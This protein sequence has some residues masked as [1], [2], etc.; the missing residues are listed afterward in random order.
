MK[1]EKMDKDDISKPCIHAGYEIIPT[2]SL[3]HPLNPE[4]LQKKVCKR[5]SF[6]IDFNQS[7]FQK[8]RRHKN[9]INLRQ[10]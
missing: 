6:I 3:L 10:L 4:Y 7:Q 5:T 2:V 8:E 1:R 9:I